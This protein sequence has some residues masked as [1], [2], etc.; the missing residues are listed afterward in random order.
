MKEA[1]SG[2]VMTETCNISASSKELTETISDS[3]I[4]TQTNS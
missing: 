2:A 4:V 3:V 1:Q